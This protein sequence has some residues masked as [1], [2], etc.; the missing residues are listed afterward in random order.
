MDF[1]NRKKTYIQ[2]HRPDSIKHLELR[3]NSLGCE[4]VSSFTF[5]MPFIFIYL[6][7]CKKGQR[8]RRHLGLKSISCPKDTTATGTLHYL[9]RSGS[10][11]QHLLEG[12]AAQ[13][14]PT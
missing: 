5:N 12:R 10:V 8:N 13:A 14:P 4:L 3:N 1:F 6:V 11:A 7:L 2:V 9:F